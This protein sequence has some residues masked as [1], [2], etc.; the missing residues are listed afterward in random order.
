M[1]GCWEH[2]WLPIQDH[3]LLFFLLPNT[4]EFGVRHPSSF[5]QPCISGEADANPI[6]RQW[7]WFVYK[8]TTV[9]PLHLARLYLGTG[10]RPSSDQWAVRVR[11]L[12]R[13]LGKFPCFSKREMEK[14]E[15]HS[16]SPGRF[17]RRSDGWACSSHF[18]TSLKIKP[19]S[20]WQNGEKETS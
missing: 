6:S 1:V 5:K 7:L 15:I 2:A 16:S 13:L 18:V 14:K 20:K 17:W 10:M 12:R 11:S 4:N 3:P 8:P 9:T 19:T